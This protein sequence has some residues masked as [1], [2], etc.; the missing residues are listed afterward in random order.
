MEYSAY[1]TLEVSLNNGVAV[2]TLNQPKIMN[3]LVQEM[4]DEL[5][6]LTKRLEKDDDVKVVVLTGNG[7]AFCAGGDLNRFQ[8]GFTLLEAVQYVKDI[9][10]WVLD[11]I[12]MSK[13]TIAAVNGYAA[14]AG[15]CVALM[16]DVILASDQAKFSSDFI[17]VGIV[18]DLAGMYYL[19]RI[20]GPHRAKELVFTG[21]RVDAEEALRLGLANRVVPNEEL[22]NQA[23]ELAVQLANGPLFAIKTAKK[24]LNMSLDLSLDQL[25]SMEAYAQGIC[26]QTKDAS[27]A[28][29]AFLEKRKPQFIGE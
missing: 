12:H 1:Q 27:E 17:N 19:P 7:R 18:P 15:L 29:N 4:I 10:P 14:G 20:L 13:P 26:F 5:A 9:H 22:L 24:M 23:L 28:I 11:W 2:V 25:V 8:Q 21:R 16:C 3:A 6:E